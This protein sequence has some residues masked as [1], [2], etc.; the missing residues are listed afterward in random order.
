MLIPRSTRGICAFMKRK[1][2]IIDESGDRKYFT[3]I[4][5]YIANHSTAIDQALYF[6]M[7]RYAGEEGQCFATSETIINKL[8]I[9]RKAYNKSLRYLLDKEWIRFIGITGGKTRPIKTYAI[10]DIWKLNVM[11]YEKIPSESTVSIEKDSVPKEGD[12]V[13]KNTKIVSESTVEEEP[14]LRTTIKKNTDSIESGGIGELLEMFRPVNPSIN[15]LFRRSNQ[16]DAIKRLLKD[17]PRPK[18]DQIIKVLPRTNAMRFAPTITTPLQ[19]E[20]RM[21]ALKAFIEK[22]RDTT[23]SKGKEI[24]G[25]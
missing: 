24:I 25:L 4:P 21:G 13:Q 8:G 1:M 17:W 16:R 7:K 11:E 18:L 22:E 10:V 14:L 20:D 5:N 15:R 9:G 3:Q 19:L 23:N 2:K 12:T 6:Q